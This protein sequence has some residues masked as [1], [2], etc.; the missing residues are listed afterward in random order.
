[1]ASTP[2]CTA[3]KAPPMPRSRGPK[4]MSSNA[5]RAGTA[6]RSR[7]SAASLMARIIA[8]FPMVVLGVE[9]HRAQVQGRV[10]SGAAR[11]AEA[12]AYIGSEGVGQQDVLAVAVGAL[13][14]GPPAQRE[15]D[16][17]PG[18]E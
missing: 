18:S 12:G 13:P 9:Q 16:V 10:G 14:T 4:P 7:A 6:A 8:L 3:V 11:L 1:M 15:R 5:A 2:S 17:L